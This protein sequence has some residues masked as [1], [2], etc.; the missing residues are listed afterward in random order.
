MKCCICGPAKNCG[1]YIEK[2]L[3]NMETLGSFFDDYVIIIYYDKSDDDTLDKLKKYKEKNLKFKFFVN[4]APT[5]SFR[6]YNIAKARNT[7]LTLIK[8]KY[9]DWDYFIMMDCD[10]VCSGTMNLDV[11]KNNLY[12]DKWDCLSFN[13]NDYYDIWALSIYPYM[14]SFLHFNDN[15]KIHHIMKNYITN[16]LNSIQKDE[17]LCCRSAFNGFAIYRTEKFLNCC[18]DGRL[19]LD[20]IP[21]K[22]L[23]IN[24]K[25]CGPII[26]LHN[27]DC[28]H[29]SFHFE[30]I[31]KNNAKIRISPEKLFPYFSEEVSV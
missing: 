31:K 10:N 20:Y 27:E 15:H 25:L 17:L 13:K 29:R 4:L 16:K 19:R 5:F 23:K 22:I 28:E 11:L 18:Y 26:S 24:T 12:K 1:P 6:T 9:S 14:F 7:L 2:V 21:E 3:Q 8:N 30:A